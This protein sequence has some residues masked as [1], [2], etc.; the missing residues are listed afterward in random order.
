MSKELSKNFQLAV[1]L[2]RIEPIPK[3][4]IKQL[5]ELRKD[6]PNEEFELYDQL[7]DSIQ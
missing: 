1:E 3:D 2:L 7:Y 5:D 4:I 6:I